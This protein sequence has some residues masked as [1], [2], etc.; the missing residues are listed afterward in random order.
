MLNLQQN[1]FESAMLLPSC[2]FVV[3]N[4]HLCQSLPRPSHQSDHPAERRSP[5]SQAAVE[6]VN[7]HLHNLSDTTVPCPVLTGAPC[8]LRPTGFGGSRYCGCRVDKLYRLNSFVQWH[9]DK[10]IAH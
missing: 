1:H 10:R 9:K 5:A 4:V 7:W 8:S 3:R 6:A 2:A